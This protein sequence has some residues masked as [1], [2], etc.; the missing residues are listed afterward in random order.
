MKFELTLDK[1]KT[2]VL[3]CSYG[4][5]SMFLFNALYQEG[6]KFVV[7][8]VN[9]HKRKESNSEQ[10]SLE[11]YSKERNIPIE[12]LDTTG[13]KPEGN[14][15]AW[16]REIRYN[17]FKKICEK[18]D[19]NMLLVAHHQDDHLETYL[20]QQKRGGF[21]MHYGIA[22]TTTIKGMNVI[23]PMLSLSKKEIVDFNDKNNIPYSIDSSNLT[24]TYQRNKFRNHYLKEIT[25]EKRQELLEEIDAKNKEL[26]VKFEQAKIRLNDRHFYTVK[27]AKKLTLEEFAFVVFKLMEVNDAFAPVSKRQ[28]ETLKRNLNSNKANI[29]VELSKDIFY[30]QEYGEIRILR[31]KKPYSYT[32]E[33]PC[34]FECDEFIIDLR[35][36]CDDRNIHPE[37][38]PITIRCKRDTD[39][40]LINDYYVKLSRLFL[41]WKM[42]LHL[43]D[44]WPVVA[45]KDDRIIY[46]PRYRRVFVDHHKTMFKISLK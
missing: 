1:S 2:Y 33:K 18:F 16:A 40:Y 36:E 6:Y 29:K 28:L 41:D 8:H 19:T 46:I 3:A 10:S 45:N 39:K 9:Y 24:D 38:F 5:D 15:Q 11:Q 31:N 22:V 34:L 23:R 35:K 25:E 44:T 42:P 21:Y 27:C 30:F 14:F 20:I 4:P 17:F 26:D 7:A 12:M 37:D 13:L 32:I 43:R